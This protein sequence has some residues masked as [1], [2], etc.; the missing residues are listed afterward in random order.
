[1]ISNLVSIRLETVNLMAAARTSMILIGW[2]MSK[3]CDFPTLRLRSGLQDQ[4]DGL[5]MVMNNGKNVRVGHRHGATRVIWRFERG[6][7]TAGVAEDIAKAH[8]AKFCRIA[9]RL[10]SRLRRFPRDASGAAHH[11]GGVDGFVGGD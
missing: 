9:R 11:A 1:M 8:G 7:T 5:G 10:L 3:I 2:P 6:D 4:A